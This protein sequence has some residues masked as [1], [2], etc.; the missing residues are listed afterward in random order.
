MFV[1]DAEK[2]VKIWDVLETKWD[3]L[4]VKFK[5]IAVFIDHIIITIWSF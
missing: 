3:D 2:F 4:S 1:T 5:L